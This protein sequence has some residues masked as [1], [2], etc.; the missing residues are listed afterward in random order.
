MKFREALLLAVLGGFAA[1]FWFLSGGYNPTAALF[2]RG[3]AI[4]CLVFLAILV[5]RWMRSESTTPANSYSFRELVTLGLQAG[6]I[7]FIYLIGFIA[8]T[9]LYLFITPFQLQYKRW[10]V[11]VAHALV[12]TAVLTT[13]FLW[14]FNVQLPAGILWDLW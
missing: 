3:I 5:I 1:A 6:Y 7:L 4:A 8:A 13:S 10:P 11:V 14:V 2:P 9:F 12:L